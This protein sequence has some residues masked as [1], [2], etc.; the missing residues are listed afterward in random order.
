MFLLFDSF[1]IFFF[2]GGRGL[3]SVS[4]GFLNKNDRSVMC[5]VPLTS[6][7]DYLLQFSHGSLNETWV[8]NGPK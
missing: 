3:M 6:K 5:D 8:R 4:F 1:L 2:G 7:E